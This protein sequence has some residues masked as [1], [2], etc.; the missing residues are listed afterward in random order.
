MTY[1]RIDVSDDR[2][3][4]DY[5]LRINV[6]DLAEPLGL[7][8]DS[9]PTDDQVRAG[10]DALFDYVLDRI[11]VE[12]DGATCPV[13]RGDLRFIE[14]TD[15]FVEL[16]W[17][18]R[19][20][21]PFRSLA[22]EYHLFFDLD[23]LH[24]GN[25]RVTVG[26][27]VAVAPIQTDARRFSWPD[28]GSAAP[29]SW[30]AFV[31]LGVEHILFGFDHVCFLVGL[32]LVSVIGRPRGR[33]WETRGVGGAVRYTAGIV[34]SFTVAHSLTLIA[35]ALGAITLPGRIV[36]SLIAASIIWVAVENMV[37]PEPR[38][39]WLLT[40]GFG[41]VHGLGFASVLRNLLPPSDVLVPLLTF[42]VGVEL[43]QLMIVL[44]LVPLLH[45]LASRILGANDY[46]RWALPL[47]SAAIAIM[48]ALWLVERIFDLRLL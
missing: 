29:T 43:G 45:L 6:R 18:V 35:A 15:R 41:L 12:T 16:T 39:R 27:E 21:Q 9:V 17:T 33:T 32:L 36:E 1:S 46:R 42:N 26:D 40:F 3:S 38:F 7:P 25:L 20:E 10:R 24:T 37:N 5:A 11:E 19:C 34:T 31:R 44:A 2:T 47:G 4:V 8:L 28:L 14:Q 30:L 23:R 13:D 48:G 22:I